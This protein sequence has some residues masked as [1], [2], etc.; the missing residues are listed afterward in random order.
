MS[1]IKK[2]FTVYLKHVTEIQT[3]SVVVQAEEEIPT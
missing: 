1:N 3:G 2:K